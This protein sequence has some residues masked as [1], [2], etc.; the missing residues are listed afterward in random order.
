MKEDDL[1]LA[2]ATMLRG[3]FMH[4]NES[5]HH[6]PRIFARV[7]TP[8]K[9]Q[10]LL[11]GSAFLAERSI[12]L[13]GSMEQVYSVD[14][15]LNSQIEQLGLSVH[16]CFGGQALLDKGKQHP[17]YQEEL[18]KFYD[19]EYNRRSSMASALHIQAKLHACGLMP[20][21]DHTLTEG[22]A[23][24]FQT[25]LDADTQGNLVLRLGQL[26]HARW[27]AFMRS[28]GYRSVSTDKMKLYAKQ[29]EKKSHIHPIAKLHPCITDWEKL[30]EVSK[31]YTECTGFNKNFQEDDFVVVR[32]IPMIIRNKGQL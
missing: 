5:F 20:A 8:L 25:L 24:A 2:T 29:G 31:A 32:N 23:A 27:N 19:S 9:S 22:K 13:F 16:M 10:N 3:F 12:S 7:R 6:N 17:D 14:A 30:D 18:K 4:C 26:E 28:Y 15:L 11:R 21:G 1:N